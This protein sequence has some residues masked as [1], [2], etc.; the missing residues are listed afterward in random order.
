MVLAGTALLP[1]S[2][3]GD[4]TDSTVTSAGTAS[5]GGS[6]R[7]SGL[8]EEP[9]PGTI[10]GSGTLVDVTSGVSTS[11]ADRPGTSA[12]MSRRGKSGR[13]TAGE[14][15]SGVSTSTRDTPAEGSSKRSSLGGTAGR[16]LSGRGTFGRIIYREL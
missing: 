6:L 3:E 7:L 8:S 16:G 12:D 10:A 2:S 9:L 5:S 1:P 13:G 14:G 4:S 11:T 15:I